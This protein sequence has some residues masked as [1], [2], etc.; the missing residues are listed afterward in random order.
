MEKKKKIMI[1][2]IAALV[3]C[4]SFGGGYLLSKNGGVDELLEETGLTKNSKKNKDSGK[5][6]TD[7]DDGVDAGAAG[8]GGDANSGDAGN[9]GGAGNDSTQQTGY[10]D[11]GGASVG[12]RS[13]SNSYSI[14]MSDLCT[15]SDPSGISFDTRYVLYGGADCHPA[16]KASASGYSCKAAYV[17]LYAKGGKAAGEYQCFVM[18]NESDAQGLAGK[19]ASI[20][21]GGGQSSGRWGDVVYVYSSGSYVQTSIDTS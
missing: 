7:K 13:A 21:N 2:V 12:G 17:V 8:A 11:N 19:Y 3:L 16:K 5:G 20:Y 9:A 1:G 14:K 18:N 6:N 15:F 10:V 4:L